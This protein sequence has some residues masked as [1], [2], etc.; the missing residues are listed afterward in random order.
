MKLVSNGL[1][2][3]YRSV[4]KFRHSPDQLLDLGVTPLAFVTLFTFLFGTSVSGNWREY[5]QFVLPGMAVQSLIFASLG[6]AG[7]PNSDLRSGIF[8]RFRS[9]PIAQSAPLLGHILGDFVRYGITIVIVLLYGL[10]LGFRPHGT[11]LGV[12]AACGIMI[13]FSF[14]LSWPTAAIGLVAK[15]PQ[16]VS[17]YSFIIIF[18]LTFGSNIFVP[19]GKL[20]GW[21]QAWVKINPVSQVTDAVRGLMLGQP[22]GA[23]VVRALLWSVAI[24]AVFAPLAGRL[25][26]RKV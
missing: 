12:L 2:L 7:A 11:V 8:D 26:R 10:I 9:M 17:G 16:S 19:V 4:M 24:F 18:P 13:L 23:A 21:L 6:T 25:Y 22:A 20:P 14:T 5:L 15:T 1:T 3:G